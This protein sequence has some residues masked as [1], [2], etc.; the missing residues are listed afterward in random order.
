MQPRISIIVPCYNV[1]KYLSTC[2][3]SILCQ[4]HT[5]YEL[6]LVDDGSTDATG[7]I[8]DKYASNHNIITVLHEKK[9]GASSARNLGIDIA[10]GEWISFID[11]DDWVDSNYL[12]VFYNTSHSVDMIYFPLTQVYENGDTITRFPQKGTIEGK[13]SV[14]SK[15]NALKYGPLGDIFGWTVVKFFKKSII[16]EYNIR[17]VEN[18]VFREDEIFT[19]DY[20]KHINSIKVLDIPL[21][22]YR[23]CSN[24]LTAKGM[25]DSDYIVLADNI[26]R[27]L[28][29][30]HNIDFLN[31]EKQRL[32][33][34]HIDL[35]LRNARIW[36]MY[37]AMNEVY[38]FFKRKPQYKDYASNQQIVRLLSHSR[39]ISFIFL[40]LYQ[41]ITI[42]K[43]KL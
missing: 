31:K 38:T 21:Y 14:E 32:V 4:E 20:C 27:N 30:F 11:S 6:I 40:E 10:K 2:I 34:Y 28:P 43:L 19:M 33:N 42:I 8:C 25:I 15:L 22:Y 26:E 13:S 3:D 17:F 24:G 12:D 39:I 7:S 5:D 35:F 9:S 36:N 41:L 16:D 18:L 1:E 37:S 29:Y 23:V